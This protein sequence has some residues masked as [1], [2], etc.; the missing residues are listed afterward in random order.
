MCDCEVEEYGYG[1]DHVWGDCKY[2][3]ETGLGVKY[4][5]KCGTPTT[6]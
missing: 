6:C 4:C 5:T 1:C 2:S 3:K